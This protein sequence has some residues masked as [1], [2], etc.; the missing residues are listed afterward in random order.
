MLAYSLTDPPGAT[1]NGA[2]FSDFALPWGRARGWFI[3]VL[4]A[5]MAGG[6]LLPAVARAGSDRD[7]GMT[8]VIVRELATS[9]REPES[10]VRALGG[11]IER[12]MRIIDGFS[13]TLPARSL[14]DLARLPG[15]YS[16]TPDARLRMLSDDYDAGSDHGSMPFAQEATGAGEFWNAGYTG[17]GVDV[18]V[19]DTGVAPVAG[20]DGYDKIIHGPDLSPESQSPQLA[21]LDS[22]GHGTHMAGIIAGRDGD[23]VNVQ[24]GD[25]EHFYGIAPGARVVSVKVADANGYTDVSQVIAAIDWVVEHRKSDGLDIRVLNLSFGTDGIQ[26]YK[27]DPLAFAAEAAWHRGIVVVAAAGNSGYGTPALNVPAVDPFLIAV[28][29]ADPNGTYGAADDSIPSFSSYGTAARSPDV[30]A[31]GKS[32]V[33]LRVPN[34]RIDLEHPD[35]RVADRFFR[36]SGTSQAAAMVSG[37]A[38]LIIDQR[39]GIRPDQVKRL[40]MS[41]AER[42]PDADPRSQGAGMIDLKRARSQ[43]TPAYQQTWPRSTGAGTLQG[44]RGSHFLVMDG[45]RLQGEMDIFGRHFDSRTWALKS[46]TGT[47]WEDGAWNG[48]RWSGDHWNGVEWTGVEWTGVQWTG[49]QWNGVEWTGIEWTGVQWTGVEWTGVEWSTSGWGEDVWTSAIWGE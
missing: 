41:S 42:I 47:S 33:S 5:C 18:A 34:S 48:T 23:S 31:P 12:R 45:V 39:P 40:L 7:T 30:V 17:A 1:P 14:A 43:A 9:G 16:V 19:I 2:L 28:G 3:F 29:A 10:A 15:V 27:L 44:S 11:R 13:A 22:Y 20:L 21:H 24:Q 49:V 4:A 38:A 32:I 37:A 25:T 46:L 8:S 36:G 6:T 35:G 26:D